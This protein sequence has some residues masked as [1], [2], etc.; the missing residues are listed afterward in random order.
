MAGSA[1]RNILVITYWCWND[2]LVQAYTLPY[3]RIMLKVLP[4]GS[5]IHVVTLEKGD[6]VLGEEQKEEGI[7]GH[8]FRYEPFG[9]RGIGMMARMIWDLVGLV[10]R[11]G[12][13][14][15]HAWCMPAGMV[16]YLVSILTQRP[17][18]IDSYEPHAEA[19]VENGTWSRRGLAFR[20]LFLFERLQTR[21]ARV[22][23]AAVSS[24]RQ[25][26]LRSYGHVPECFHV[27]PACVDL[28]RF[29]WQNVK[30]P[31]L[32]ERYGLRGKIVVVYAGKFGG[33]YWRQ[34]VFD[35]LRV[36]YDHWGDRLHVLLLT[37]HSREELE[38]LM[39]NS[40]ID[41]ALFTIRF[42]PH[43]E[44]PDHLGLADLALTP[45]K[46][47]P[48]KRYCT[49]IKDGEYWAL[50]LPVIITPGIS[51]DSEIIQDLGIGSVV[52]G[53]DKEAFRRSIQEVDDLLLRH[54]REQLFTM[55]RPVAEKYRSFDRALEVYSKIY[56][57]T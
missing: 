27:K 33:I 25:Y 20:M 56:G 12:A 51:D 17:L 21:H 23:I 22:V 4:V 53:T 36:A 11:K 47:V 37:S 43:S 3:L 35:L 38:P 45:V 24:M 54:S 18:I 1:P 40:G 5:T 8:A 32:V 52:Q 57:S 46:S 48:T 16:G 50:G 14:T 6:T 30:R 26:A 7:V 49:P 44:M 13:D 34:E 29:G 15:V 55:I 39:T 19:M 9:R 10:R 28:D 2:A 41:P 31:E 42:V